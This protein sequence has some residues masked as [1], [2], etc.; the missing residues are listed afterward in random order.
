MESINDVNEA[1]LSLITVLDP[2]VDILI[3]GTGD[4]NVKPEFTKNLLKLMRKCRTNVEILK[5]EAAC[6]TFNFLNSENRSVAGLIIP[7]FTLPVTEDELMKHKLI[8]LEETAHNNDIDI[9]KMLK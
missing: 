8:E 2:K 7:P 4:I 6:A 1:S 5:T 3:I 9:N